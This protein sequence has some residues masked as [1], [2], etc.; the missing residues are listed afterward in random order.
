MYFTNMKKI[1][2]FYFSGTGNSKNVANWI[3]DS[4]VGN[5]I[6][7][8]VYD[9][10]KITNINFPAIKQEDI[11]IITSPIHG[12]NYPPIMINFLLRFPKGNNNI[13]LMNTRAGM[14]IKKFITPGISGIAFYLASLILIFKGYIIKGFKPINLPSNWISLHPGLNDRTIKY[15]HEEN[16]KRVNKFFTTI[17]NNKNYFIYLREF[18]TDLLVAPIALP[19]YLIGRFI[20]SKTFF[21][22]ANCNKCMLCLSNCPVK[23]IKLVDGRPYWT[24]K[25]ES[26][27]KCIGY[28]PHQAINVNHGYTVFINIIFSFI[29]PPILILFLSIKLNI[30]HYLFPVVRPVLFLIFTFIAYRVMHFLLKIKIFEKIISYTSLTRYKFWGKKYKALR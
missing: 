27:M 4:A 18:I 25:C 6:L 23:A 2:I 22:S 29:I 19:Y 1:I 28:C 20:L 26:C 17:I 24:Y 15:L 8:E 12:F 13:Y 14:L 30:L 10:S 21:A 9:I 5:N 11:L 16:K 7:C 3:Y